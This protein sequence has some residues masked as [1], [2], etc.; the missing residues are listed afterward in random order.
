MTH[1][2]ADTA[3]NTDS[4]NLAVV[5]TGTNTP[6]EQAVYNRVATG[7]GEKIHQAKVM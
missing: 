5:T 2:Q 6:T 3:L 7:L 1:L 4:T